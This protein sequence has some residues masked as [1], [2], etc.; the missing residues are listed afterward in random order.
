MLVVRYGPRRLLFAGVCLIAGGGVA[1]L[2]AVLAHAGLPG[3]LPALFVVVASNGLVA[4]NATA[5]ALAD[6]GDVAGSASALLGVAQ[7]AVGAVA[8]PLV[9]IGGSHTDVP[10]AVVIAALGLVALAAAGTLRASPSP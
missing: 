3:V 9:G 7:F 10:M 2:I 8:A 5:L 6:H 1:L 4:P